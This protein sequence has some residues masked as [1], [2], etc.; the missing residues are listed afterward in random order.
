LI[1][2]FV[3]S[4]KQIPMDAKNIF[5]VCSLLLLGMLQPAAAQSAGKSL[6][7][8]KADETGYIVKVGDQAPDFTMTLI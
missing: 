1:V 6:P 5:L 8:P 2:S 4:K 3:I 7:E